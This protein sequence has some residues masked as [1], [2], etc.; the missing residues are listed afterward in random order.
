MFV[1]YYYYIIYHQY[2][3]TATARR[4]QPQFSTA[5]INFLL[6]IL[7]IIN[8]KLFMITVNRC[9]VCGPD[10][11]VLRRLV[12]ESCQ[13]VE[14]STVDSVIAVLADHVAL[15]VRLWPIGGKRQLLW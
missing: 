6:L 3:A 15:A 13:A 5:L 1:Y 12:Q 9:C 14:V 7:F 10:N 11:R 2:V 4:F 8:I